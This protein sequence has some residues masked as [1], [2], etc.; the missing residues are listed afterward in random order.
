MTK[1]Y[2]IYDKNEKKDHHSTHTVTQEFPTMVHCGARN[3]YTQGSTVEK[4]FHSIFMT[5]FPLFINLR[6]SLFFH[7]FSL[8]SLF[9]F[10]Q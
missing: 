1:I 4:T 9:S 5:S 3:I 10:L 6:L 8:S 7:T 2:I